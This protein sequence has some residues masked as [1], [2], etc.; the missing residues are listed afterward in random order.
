VTQLP[1]HTSVDL[2]APA[3]AA[4]PA[5]FTSDTTAERFEFKFW[6]TA[7]Q[8]SA[9]LRIGRSHLIADPF[10]RGGFQRNVSL[11]LDSP[12]RSFYDL[13]R[14]GAPDRLKLRVRTYDELQDFAFLEVKR[15]I[16]AVT[17][18]QRAMVPRWMAA[19]VVDGRFEAA[20]AMAPTAD[21][22]AFLYHHQRHRV[23]PVL[24]V[25]AQRQALSG[26]EDEGSFRLT[27][28]RDIRYQR[29]GTADLE[30]RP[31]GWIPVDVTARS[32]NR[33]LSILIELKFRDAAPA[34][35]EPVISRLGMRPTSFSKYI[36]AL[37]QDLDDGCAGHA[38][39]GDGD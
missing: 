24:L 37:A 36:G 2:A 30:G 21:L 3:P 6:A 16:K 7:E 20:D 26:I 10:S 8:T 34:W 11:Y 28:D 27:V 38:D 35:I 1:H 15:K 17:L 4:R 19:A 9:L 29:C 12:G 23:E 33:A 5:F 32:G 25:S 31:R 18:K 22:Q 39:D 13:H 14:S